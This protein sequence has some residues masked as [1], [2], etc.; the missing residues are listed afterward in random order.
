M[1]DTKITIIGA[2]FVGMSLAALLSQAN[3]VVV[4]D[5]DK[6]KVRKINAM[7]STVDDPGI[8][9]ALQSKAIHLSATTNSKEALTNSNYVFIATPTNFNEKTS[10]L[11]MSSVEQVIEEAL[12]LSDKQSL[13]IIKSTVQIGFTKAQCLK[14]TTER[15]IF[16]PEFL[17]EGHALHDNLYPSRLIVGGEKNALTSSFVRIMKEAAIDKK[18][19]I[20]FMASNEAESVKLFSNTFLAMRVAFFNELD[21]FAIEKN[22][23][24][25]SIIQGVSLDARIGDYYNNPSFGYGGYCLPK[26]TKQL[27]S[28]YNDIPQSLIEATIQSNSKRKA[29]LLEKIIEMNVKTLGVYRLVMKVGSDNYRESAILFLIDALKDSDFELIIY[30]PK[31]DQDSY[32]GIPLLKNLEDFISRSDMIVAN[33]LSDELSPVHHKIFSRDLFTRDV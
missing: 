18:F 8:A 26:D 27:L 32:K 6:T 21:N 29:F 1:P 5:I 13:I 20:L 30:E 3:N 23:N 12:N 11:D 16:S 17:R 14:Y 4:L 9:E 25:G 22:M 7:Q 28:S 24:T 10:L 15:I 2:G 31:M 33:R 19:T